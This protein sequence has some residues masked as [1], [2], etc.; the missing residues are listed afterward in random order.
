[1]LQEQ[2]MPE[3]R[4]NNKKNHIFNR[5]IFKSDMAGVV[6]IAA[7]N[8]IL[9]LVTISRFGIFRDELYYLD[10]A[11][12]LA[13]GFVDQPPL[14]I[15]LLKGI[16]LL[17]GE[18]LVFMRLLPIICG[19]LFIF[20]TGLLAWE[21]GGKKAAPTLAAAAAFAVTGNFF[22]FHVFSM[23]SLD[24]IFWLVIFFLVIRIIKTQNPRLWIGLGIVAGL[25]LQNKISILFLL[26]GI[27]LGILLTKER[28]NL[29]SVYF[30][31]GGLISGLL[32]LPYIIWN[33]IH[34]WP[35]LE[36]MHNA[37]TFKMVAVSPLKFL[38]GQIVFNNPATLII[39]LAGLLSLLFW[40]NKKF[41]LFGLMYLAIYI[42]FTI[43]GAK[44]Y[45]LAAAYPVLF[46]AG[47]VQW[48]TWLSRKNLR[49]L[50]PSLAVLLIFS[51]LAF[52][53]IGLPILPVEK[54]AAF[55]AH[56]G[57]TDMGS[58]RHELAELPQHFAD[59][60]GWSALASTVSEVYASLSA[61]EQQSCIIFTQNYGEAGAINQLGK[62]LGLPRAYSGHN[63]HFF[64]PPPNTAGDVVIVI[65][66]DYEDLEAGFSEVILSARTSCRYCIPYENN[67]PIYICRGLTSPIK[68]LWP[69]LKHFN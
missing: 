52:C 51:G 37:K 55:S 27:Y 59:M 41:R 8:L 38:V 24:C 4:G 64:W 22:N 60:F 62:K 67:R 14:S 3:Q 45:Y 17:G 68:D 66:G 7:L 56:M 42:L 57:L 12:H 44:D 49:W 26:F 13:F 18:S 32:F 31:T 54:T 20:L 33:I 11:D 40:A 28:N 15:L 16:R 65:G 50:K 1:M 34:D 2:Q 36:F 63:N 30:W 48:E 5:A 10:C 23:N 43:Q 39:W 35:L 9:H 46:A 29:R 69:S 25:G 21:L 47:A 19:A 53:W 61:Q 58:E 6:L